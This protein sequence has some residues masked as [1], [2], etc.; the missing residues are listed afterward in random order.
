MG[1]LTE[2]H[3]EHCFSLPSTPIGVAIF[4]L[5]FT[6]I[7]GKPASMY[8]VHSH[9]LYFFIKACKNLVEKGKR[10]NSFERTTKCIISLQH[11]IRFVTIVEVQKIGET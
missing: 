3:S 9:P 6:P 5:T 8:V 11:N 2:R 10:G 7:L 4:I 1:H